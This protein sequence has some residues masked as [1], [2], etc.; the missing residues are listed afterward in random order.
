MTEILVQDAG[1]IFWA[2]LVIGAT[3]RGIKAALSWLR[4]R[5]GSIVD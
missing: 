5:G 2:G 3:W 1:S 4:G